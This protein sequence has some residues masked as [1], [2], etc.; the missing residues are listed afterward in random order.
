MKSIRMRATVYFG[1]F[2]LNQKSLGHDF[3]SAN[4]HSREQKLSVKAYMI[5][6]T[7]F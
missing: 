1:L 6:R 3:W 5:W 4:R 7:G 2:I